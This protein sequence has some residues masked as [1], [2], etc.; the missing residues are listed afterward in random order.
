MQKPKFEY[1]VFKF[2]SVL[3]DAVWGCILS[4]FIIVSVLLAVFDKFSPYSYQNN[5][6]S[7]DGQGE[8]PRVFSLKEGLWFCMT[9][10]TP[11][12]GGEA[13]RALS[14]RE[15]RIQILGYSLHVYQ[16]GWLLQHGGC[17]GS[18]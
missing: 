13:P 15:F 8:E 2:M 1:S 9:S 10:L 12:G 4:A 14:G 7:W 6:S 11:Q 17:L 16:G 5:R 18:S 3:E